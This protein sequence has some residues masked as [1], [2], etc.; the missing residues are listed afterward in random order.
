MLD[1]GAGQFRLEEYDLSMEVRGRRPAGIWLAATAVI[2][3]ITLAACTGS[4]HPTPSHAAK[5]RPVFYLIPGLSSDAFY[6]TMRQGAQSAAAQLGIK[7]IYQGSPYAFNPAAQIPYLDAAIA[8]HPDAILIAPTDKHALIAPIRRAVRSGIPVIAVDT[9]IT[10]PLAVTNVRS[11]NARGG[12]LAAEA[13]ARA[14]HFRGTVAALSVRRGIST[15][16]RRQQG[17]VRQLRQYKQIRYLGTQYDGD[18]MASARRITAG[19]LAKHPGLAGIFAMNGLSGDGVISALQATR[20]SHRVAL[21]EFDADPIQ[22]QALRQGAVQALIAQDPWEIGNRA[23][24]LAHQWVSGRR[25]GIK[26]LYRTGEVILTRRTI[27][28]PSLRHFLYS[29]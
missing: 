1:A 5:K 23:V 2:A 19:I 27:D 4:A 9:F 28:D 25:S 17:F 22:V 15:T 18:V 3:A 29:G 12:A 20:R 7:L 24:Q 11:R 13:L 8:Q 10:A 21:V 26:K 16:D 14:V 6:I